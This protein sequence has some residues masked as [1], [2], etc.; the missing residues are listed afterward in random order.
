MAG[1]SGALNIRS[2]LLFPLPF[3][4]LGGGFVLA[5]VGILGIHLLL[6]FILI[7]VGLF[8]ITSYEGTEINTRTGTYREYNSYFF[9]KRGEAKPFSGIEKIY[10]N[11][12][13]VSQA[14]YTAHTTSS[15]T[16]TNTEYRAYIKFDGGE[17]VLLL[18]GRNKKKLLARTKQIAESLNTSVHDNT[19]TVKSG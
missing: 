19:V 9:L 8:I 12:A 15:S 13:K 11:S 16:F 10:I 17:R 6:A 3:L 4:F 7:L 1:T 2:G 5:G 18:S 14:V